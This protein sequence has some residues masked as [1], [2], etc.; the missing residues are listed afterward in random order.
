MDIYFHNF[1]SYLYNLLYLQK[2]DYS[3]NK[4]ELKPYFADNKEEAMAAF[5]GLSGKLT[6]FNDF[7]IFENDLNEIDAKVDREEEEEER[8]LMELKKRE[9]EEERRRQAAV[10]VKIDALR[11]SIV[12]NRVRD[13]FVNCF[14]ADYQVIAA[15]KEEIKNNYK[16]YCL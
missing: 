2:T 9:E 11:N 1:S 8:R 5:I 13:N 4:K 7:V 10:Q 14:V 6:N 15:D 16:L 12:V 3:D